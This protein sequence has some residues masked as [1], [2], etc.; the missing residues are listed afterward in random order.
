MT[1]FG[2]CP[3]RRGN[4]VTCP[5]KRWEGVKCAGESVS[6]EDSGGGV[7]P[8]AHRAIVGAAFPIGHGRLTFRAQ[9]VMWCLPTTCAVLA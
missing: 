5:E 9:P 6:G 8:L 2:L 7:D 4:G 1:P 3:Q